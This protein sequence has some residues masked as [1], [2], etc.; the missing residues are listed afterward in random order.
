MRV[1]PK[2]YIKF[3]GKFIDDVV[4][5]FTLLSVTG[6]D[7]YDVEFNTKIYDGVDGE[8]AYNSR[9]PARTIT[10]NYNLKAPTPYTRA[11]RYNTLR[12]FLNVRDA[13]LI[14]ADEA[15]KYL[16]VAFTSLTESTIEFSCFDPYKYSTGERC[17]FAD[18]DG[19]LI[20]ENNGTVP[21]AVRYE[22]EGEGHDNGYIGIV[23][24]HG[25]LEFGKR[26]D[27]DYEIL[28][29]NEIL[30][31]QTDLNK[32]PDNGGVDAFR[33]NNGT[34][35]TLKTQAF[36]GA[37]SEVCLTY[38]TQ[39]TRGSGYYSGGSR[40]VT[41]PA[42]SSGD[43]SG[44]ANFYAWFMLLFHAGAM[45]QTGEMS[46][47]FLDDDD[48]LV[49]GVR[50]AKSDTSGNWAYYQMYGA[51]RKLK[52]IGFEAH[53]LLEK[54]PWY[55]EHGSCDLQKSGD[56]LTFYWRCTYPKFKLP[57]IKDKKVTKVQV[58]FKAYIGRTG[59]KLVTEMGLRRF[60]FT[61]NNVENIRDIPNRYPADA[62]IVIN[63]ETGEFLVNGQ[64]KPFDEVIGSTYFKV[65][66]GANE[67]NVVFSDWCDPKPHVTAYIRERWL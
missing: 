37:L 28:K 51:G 26:S 49:A 47:G 67:I 17:F 57:E 11:Q 24:E 18:D 15:D 42:D 23:S 16:N 6:R 61:K 2:H 10:V 12:S 60:K 36:G 13:Q 62:Q 25:S 30:L 31:T 40:T 45:G 63:G 3:N 59:D 34:A 55:G 65:E 33:P 54:N 48:Y 29:S 22:I 52:E 56:T 64:P 20:I 1:N 58:G 41:I 21:C 43:S 14:F 39:G 66:P 46:I 5:G 4:E 7:S 38:G 32:A 50:L 27:E 44:A 53:H 19:V 35:G 9:I 8:T